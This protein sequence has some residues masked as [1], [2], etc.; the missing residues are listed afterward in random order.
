MTTQAKSDAV[1]ERL[2]SL[3]PKIIDLSL[4]RTERLLANHGHPEKKMPPVIHVAGTNGKGSTV[5]F[6]RAMLEAAGKRVHVYT[7]PHLVRFH[8]RIRL[9]GQL[10][11]EEALLEM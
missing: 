5:A 2:Q 3:H 7:S 4:G 11:S 8:E 1:L 9:A 6:M 10:I